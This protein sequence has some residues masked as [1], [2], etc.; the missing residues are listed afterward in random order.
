MRTK[1]NDIDKT[2]LAYRRQRKHTHKQTRKMIMR[3][4]DK[5]LEEIRRQMRVHLDE[6][7]LNDKR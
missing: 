5:I 7:L 1:C 4:L 6:E 2:I 3:L